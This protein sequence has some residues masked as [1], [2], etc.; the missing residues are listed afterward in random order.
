MLGFKLNHV[1]KRGHR[2]LCAC[3]LTLLQFY[4]PFYVKKEKK[5]YNL[6]CLLEFECTKRLKVRSQAIPAS[7]LVSDVLPLGAVSYDKHYLSTAPNSRCILSYRILSYLVAD[8]LPSGGGGVIT[9]ICRQHQTL[10]ASY[11]ILSYLIADV[12]PSGAVSY[13]HYLSTAPHSRCT[14]S[15]LILS[16][17][18]CAAIGGGVLAGLHRL[19]VGGVSGLGC[20]AKWSV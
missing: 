17:C 11:L 16:R 14:L 12:L 1:S 20:L 6:M 2:C 15:Y 4:V 9:N 19:E 5:M 7:F 18:R 10:Y 8:V 3:F 13:K